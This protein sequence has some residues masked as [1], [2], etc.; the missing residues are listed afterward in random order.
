MTPRHPIQPELQTSAGSSCDSYS[1]CVAI[2][3]PKQSSP[4]RHVAMFSFDSAAVDPVTKQQ[5]PHPLITPASV[6][7]P[8]PMFAD[9]FNVPAVVDM[10]G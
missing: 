10:R 4:R 1:P 5:L 7:L 3:S 9:V 8:S 6:Q 2:H